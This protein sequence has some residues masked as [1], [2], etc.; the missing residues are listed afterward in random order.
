MKTADQPVAVV[1]GASKGIGLAMAQS[2]GRQGYRVCGQSRRPGSAGGM[3]WIPCDVTDRKLVQNA[4]DEIFSRA[5]HIDVLVNNAGMGISGAVEYTSEEE[6]HRQL[7]VNF[8]GAV[9]CTQQ[10][11]GPM[12]ERG[13]GRI[14]FTSSLAA[15]FPLP[16]QSFYSVSK[17]GIDAFSDALR[18]ELKPFGVETSVLLLND[19]RTEFT[20]SRQKTCQGDTV[21]GGRITKSVGKMEQSERSGMLPDQV[22]EAMVRLLRRR[23]L[24][25]HK[26]IGAGNELLGVLY[27][28]LPAKTMLWLLSKLYG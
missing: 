27:R 8:F 22:A 19:V 7:E 10:V 16:F 20:D 6:L 12:R 18:L 25:P 3:E 28:I 1:T 23:R 2:L 5:S 24:P 17:A 14:L 11:I 15:I 9:A 13:K 4:F 26:I 21:Y